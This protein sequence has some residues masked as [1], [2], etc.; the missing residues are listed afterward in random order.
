[1]S[2]GKLSQRVEEA[3]LC[4]DPL[5]I[6]TEDMKEERRVIIFIWG[7]RRMKVRVRRARSCST[8]ERQ[9]EGLQ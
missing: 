6:G 5:F 7:R 8:R 9:R 4:L 1:M 2:P 3:Q